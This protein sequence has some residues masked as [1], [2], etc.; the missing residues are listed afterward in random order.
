MS[1]RIQPA[2]APYP[3][4]IQKTLDQLTT[5]GAEPL[6]AAAP[7]GAAFSQAPP[8]TPHG[9]PFRH[10]WH[11]LGQ[12]AVRRGDHR[13]CRCTTGTAV[14]GVSRQRERAQPAL[15]SRVFLGTESPAAVGDDR[16]SSADAIRT[17]YQADKSRLGGWENGR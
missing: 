12:G 13:R 15:E 7:A 1:A 11:P 3:S 17:T 5:P 9:D 14:A 4:S 8:L 6:A 10:D 16:G 2:Q